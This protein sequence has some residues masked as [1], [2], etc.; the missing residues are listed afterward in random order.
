MIVYNIT[1]GKTYESIAAAA[2]ATGVSA[3][4]ISRASQKETR[5]AGGYQW[6][7]AATA[8]E[9]RA[10]SRK[11][12][13]AAESLSEAQ[14]ERRDWY[15][16][17]SERIVAERK[18]AEKR[19]KEQA[20]AEE[21]ARKAAE[22][23]RKRKEREHKQAVADARRAI[24]ALRRKSKETGLSKQVRGMVDQALRNLGVGDL[25]EL[26]EMSTDALHGIAGRAAQTFE[27]IAAIEGK[28]DVGRLQILFGLSEQK[29]IMY[30]Q[31]LRTLLSL[32][33]EIRQFVT[34][35]QGEAGYASIRLKSAYDTMILK[36]SG[37]TEDNLN[38]LITTLRDVIDEAKRQNQMRADAI[39][40]VIGEWAKEVDVGHK[41]PRKPLKRRY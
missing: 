39:T 29:A 35:V 22:R 31:Q 5:S 33:G 7:R 11:A 20:A 19:A 18:A 24:K 38:S 8:A 36:S 12:H 27:S 17:R 1:T 37:Y 9:K 3:S 21:R 32:Y 28:E 10:A 15:R 14:R 41:K 30:Q 40:K 25:T 16:A 4:S 26:I 2:R 6:A 34:S 13:K 23:E